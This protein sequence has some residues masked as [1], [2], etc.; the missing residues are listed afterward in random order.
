MDLRYCEEMDGVSIVVIERRP[1]H[2][3]LILVE[4]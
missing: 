2:G 3:E 1:A 4:Q